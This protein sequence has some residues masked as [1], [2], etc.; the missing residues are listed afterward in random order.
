[1][2]AYIGKNKFALFKKIGSDS[3]CKY[4]LETT[5]TTKLNYTQI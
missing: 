3:V 5:W 2:T 1:M 4:S